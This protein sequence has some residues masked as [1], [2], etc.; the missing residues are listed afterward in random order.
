MGEELRLLPG[1]KGANQ[2]V[3]AKRA[4]AATALVGRLGDDPF[5]AEL[6]AF[7]DSEEVDLSLTTSLEDSSCRHGGDRC[8]RLRQHDHRD[9]GGQRAARPGAV[10]G[11]TFGARP[12][13]PWPSSRRPQATTRAAFAKAKAAGARTI[14]NPAPAAELV[15]GSRAV[16]LPR[17][18]RER[19][20]AA[21]P[22]RMP[23]PAEAADRLRCS[24]E[25][26]IVVTLGPAGAVIRD[27]QG[28]AHIEGLSVQAVDTT[29]AGDCFVG[30][31]AAALAEG[32]IVREAAE[33]ANRAAS[34]CV[35]VM[36]AG[37]SMPTREMTRPRQIR[38]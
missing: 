29:G 6:P 26:T 9:R 21:R 18:Q 37:V 30:N 2:A 23:R 16:R 24:D 4:G 3:A 25:Q 12:T 19:A 28:T 11:V 1:G 5:A 22:E 36:G 7:L 13:S 35:Q 32:Q 8:R 34:L 27:G 17:A 10:D 20:R 33:R 31:L 14:L 38:G 15:A